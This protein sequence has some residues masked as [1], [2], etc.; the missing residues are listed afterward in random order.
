MLCGWRYQHQFEQIRDLLA[1]FPDQPVHRE[2][3]ELAAEYFNLCRSKGIQGSHTDFLI[4]ACSVS[5][6][7]P[8]LTKDGDY[9]RYAEHVPLLMYELN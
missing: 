8:I 9:A 7:M 5:W 6:Q 2:Q 1:A 4:C 3:Y